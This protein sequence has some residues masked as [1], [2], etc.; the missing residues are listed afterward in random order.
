MGR[1][2][3]R[4]GPAANQSSWRFLCVLGVFA[5]K[6]LSRIHRQDAKSAKNPRIRIVSRRRRIY[7][8]AALMPRVFTDK[9][10]VLI[11]SIGVN[12]FPMV[13]RQRNW[14]TFFLER[15]LLEYDLG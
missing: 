1:G 8:L 2:C 11:R 10:S 13:N 6:V 3:T 5:V 9:K 4:R 12:P 7:A 15:S 14:L